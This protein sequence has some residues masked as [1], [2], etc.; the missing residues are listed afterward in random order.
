MS[1]FVTREI[2][3]AE[4]AFG[5]LA[6]LK[7][8]ARN[9]ILRKAVTQATR[10]VLAGVKGYAKKIRDSGLLYRSLGSKVKTYSNG[11]VVGI[12][13]PRKGFGQVVVSKTGKREKRDP[14]FYAHLVERGTQAH[15]LGKGANIR[16]SRRS[17]GLSHLHPGAKAQPFMRPGWDQSEAPARKRIAEVV[18]AEIEG[19]K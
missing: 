3:G 4:A 1:G 6:E 2:I 18:L 12:V 13:G 11:T 8:S 10:L 17:I 7:K 5:N 9:K 16:S 14:I 19:L 15:Q